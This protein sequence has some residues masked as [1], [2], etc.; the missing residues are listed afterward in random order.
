VERIEIPHILKVESV[1]KKV[2]SGDPKIPDKIVTYITIHIQEK[3]K[4]KYTSL[5]WDAHL[6]KTTPFQSQYAIHQFPHYFQEK[7]GVNPHKL[8]NTAHLMKDF[9]MYRHFLCL[10]IISDP[11]RKKDVFVEF[12]KDFVNGKDKNI[13]NTWVINGDR[14]RNRA[15]LGK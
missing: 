6:L 5:D 1:E 9:M 7:T 8:F 10:D 13:E 14:I 2:P 11:K 3:E 15:D 4:E 12:K